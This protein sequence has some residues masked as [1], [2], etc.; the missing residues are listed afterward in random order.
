MLRVMKV[1]VI[2]GQP[3]Y[4]QQCIVRAEVSSSEIRA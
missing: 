3:R 1:N 2:D 4:Q